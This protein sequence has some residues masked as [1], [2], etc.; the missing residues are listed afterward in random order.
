MKLDIE[1]FQCRDRGSKW[2]KWFPACLLIEDRS[3]IAHIFLRNNNQVVWLEKDASSFEEATAFLKKYG[4]DQ[5]FL[6]G[7]IEKAL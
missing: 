3:Y 4:D 1:F 5:N 2:E 6:S 7:S